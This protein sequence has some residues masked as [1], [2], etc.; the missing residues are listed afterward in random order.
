MP[1]IKTHRAAA[2]RLKVTGSGKIVRT[3]AFKRH[4]MTCKARK[5]KRQLKPAG[6]VDSAN[7]VRARRMLPNS[8]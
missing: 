7:Q 4:Q 2:K 8:L 1:K 3:H 5:A 6:L